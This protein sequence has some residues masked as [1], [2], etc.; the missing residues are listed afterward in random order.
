ML[1]VKLWSDICPQ[2]VFVKCDSDGVGVSPVD[3]FD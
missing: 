3:R 2:N 1:P